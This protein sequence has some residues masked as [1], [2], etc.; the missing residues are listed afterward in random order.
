MIHG[1]AV[2]LHDTTRVIPNGTTAKS[3]QAY[4]SFSTE[5]SGAGDRRERVSP[6]R[7]DHQ[8]LTSGHAP[9]SDIRQTY[10]NSIRGS[11]HDKPPKTSPINH[12]DLTKPSSTPRPGKTSILHNPRAWFIPPSRFRPLPFIHPSIPSYHSRG[13]TDSSA[14]EAMSSP[15]PPA[16]NE[17][18]RLNRNISSTSQLHVKRSV[19]RF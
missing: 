16:P 4:R 19:R 7:K 3:I 15:P 13:R 8:C 9:S 6:R 10:T 18:F 14:E 17:I 5:S 12:T 1:I 2:S 11:D